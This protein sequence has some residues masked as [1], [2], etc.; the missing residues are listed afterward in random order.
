MNCGTI[1]LIMRRFNIFKMFFLNDMILLKRILFLSI[2]LTGIMIIAFYYTFSKIN[3]YM[4]TFAIVNMLIVTLTLS[5]FFLIKNEREK[6]SMVK[7]YKIL[8]ISADDIYLTFF[9]T[10]M[11]LFFTMNI[12]L[13]LLS[14]IYKNTIIKYLENTNISLYYLMFFI[15]ILLPLIIVFIITILINGIIFLNQRFREIIKYMYMLILFI[16]VFG[17]K[18]KIHFIDAPNINIERWLFEGN[19]FYHFYIIGFLIIL[20]IY[21]M[22]FIGFKKYR[23]QI[24]KDI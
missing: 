21:Y 18:L 5:F 22:F 24:Y 17:N 6:A 12:P 23:I 11:L 4:M 10:P 16:L 13:L 15:H 2:L 8:P 14:F 20:L 7:V 1:L 3:F 19:S 9:V